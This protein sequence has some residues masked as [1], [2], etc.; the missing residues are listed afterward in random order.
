MAGFLLILLIVILSTTIR[1]K[2]KV[3]LIRNIIAT[4]YILGFIVVIANTGE[5]Y[6]DGNIVMSFLCF[7]VYLIPL[8]SYK[9][10]VRMKRRIYIQ[11]SN[12]WN[13]PSVLIDDMC[14]YKNNDVYDY[15]DLLYNWDRIGIKQTL[16][17][18]KFIMT[19][20]QTQEAIDKLYSKS[21]ISKSEM[22]DILEAEALLI[23][24]L[25]RQGESDWYS[26]IKEAVLEW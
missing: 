8:L 16:R 11:K 26:A 1:K 23:K 24:N 7:F 17:T 22:I 21:N 25:N 19:S 2:G 20:K 13:N 15:D 5:Y 6:R 14:E 4:I 10:I 18:G 12:N 3:R 9:A